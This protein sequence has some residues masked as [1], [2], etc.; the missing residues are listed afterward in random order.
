[1]G[2]TVS[3]DLHVREVSFYMRRPKKVKFESDRSFHQSPF[4]RNQNGHYDTGSLI[5][6]IEP[7]IPMYLPF[8]RIESS[9]SSYLQGGLKGDI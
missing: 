3:C 5:D 4:G 9:E 2:K 1:M 8:S 6:S 7:D